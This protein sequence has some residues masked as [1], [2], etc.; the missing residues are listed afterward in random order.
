[1]TTQKTDLW[2]GVDSRLRT[3]VDELATKIAAGD[4]A[5][6]LHFLDHDEYGVAFEMLRDLLIENQTQVPAATFD[7]LVE[8]ARMMDLD[9][10]D[11]ELRRSFTARPARN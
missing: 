7:T 9:A 3:V 1:V 10:H 5:T 8:L 4:I 6:I 11:A 2:A